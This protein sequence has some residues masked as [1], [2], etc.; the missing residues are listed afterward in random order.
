VST[1]TM[2]AAMRKPRIAVRSGLER[3]SGPLMAAP[4]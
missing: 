3:L 2:S 4:P 1:Y